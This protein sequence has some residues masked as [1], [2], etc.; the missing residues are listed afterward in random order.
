[1]FAQTSQKKNKFGPHRSRFPLKNSHADCE[2]LLPSDPTGSDS[3]EQTLTRT[4]KKE[5]F[6]TPPGNI[7]A[8]KRK[9]TTS[10]SHQNRQNTGPMGCTQIGPMCLNCEPI[11]ASPQ[12]SFHGSFRQVVLGNLSAIRQNLSKSWILKGF[13][14]ILKHRSE[15]HANRTDVSKL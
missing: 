1:M 4:R 13:W 15:S 10:A 12:A 9:K 2:K 6:Q 5:Y 3:R 8:N 14:R 7:R 11:R